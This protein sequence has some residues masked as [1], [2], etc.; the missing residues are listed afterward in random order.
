MPDRKTEVGADL[1]DRGLQGLIERGRLVGSNR[2]RL[3]QPE[4]LLTVMQLTRGLLR[5]GLGSVARPPLPVEA[6]D[7]HGQLLGV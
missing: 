4:M 2:D 7:E 5:D 6:L 1:V 3:K